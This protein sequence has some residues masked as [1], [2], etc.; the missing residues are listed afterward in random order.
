MMKEQQ[1]QEV[2]ECEGCN[3]KEKCLL[4]HNIRHNGIYR[5]VC[6]LCVLRLNSGWFCWICFQVFEDV[7]KI[8]DDKVLCLKSQC[9]S[10]AHTGCA[11]QNY[12]DASCIYMCPL[13]SIPNLTFFDISSLNHKKI[14]GSCCCSSSSSSCNC[15][16]NDGG[17]RID[18]KLSKA[19]VAASMFASISINKAAVATQKEVEYRFQE[20]AIAK[21]KATKALECLNILSNKAQEEN[22]NANENGDEIIGVSAA[23]RPP[24]P[25]KKKKK[26]SKNNGV[27]A[28]KKGKAVLVNVGSVKKKKRTILGC[29]SFVSKNNSK[30]HASVENRDGLKKQKGIVINGNISKDSTNLQSHI[31]HE[32]QGNKGLLS[33]LTGTG[34]MQRPYRKKRSVVK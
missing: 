23:R 4:L 19:L 15:S 9:P 21:K 2:A 3:I 28:D 1:Q 18:L 32:D 5:R 14:R 11:I 22:A 20:A 33:A 27:S 12:H 17:R 31:V 26:I 16:S 8:P 6:S 29:S 24:P 13:C 25:P 10:I 30:K 7:S 34:Q